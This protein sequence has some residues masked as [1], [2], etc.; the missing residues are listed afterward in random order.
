M[1]NRRIITCVASIV[2]ALAMLLACFPSDVKA[3][4]NATFHMAA[5]KK[6]LEL[7]E[8]RQAGLAYL[9]LATL[10]GR[11]SYGMAWDPT[12]GTDQLHPSV[13]VRRQKSVQDWI[14]MG[15][16][17]GDEPEGPMALR[18][19]YNPL[20]N[21]QPWLTDQQWI[22][23]QLQR[24]VS[25]TIR[26]PEISLVDWAADTQKGEIDEYFLPQKYSWPDAKANFRLALAS[27]DPDNDYYGAAWRAVGETMHLVA[28]LTLPPHVRND[29]H[30][31]FSR[32][33]GLIKVGDP[34]PLEPSTLAGPVDQYDFSAGGWTTAVDYE[35]DVIQM[36]RQLA[37]WTNANFLSKDTIPLPGWTTTANGGPIFPSPNPIG[38][39]PNA[40]G[41]IVYNVDGTEYRMVRQSAIY[42]SGVAPRDLYVIDGGVI[43]DQRKLLIPTAVRAAEAVIERFLPRFEVE[44]E[45]EEDSGTPGQYSVHGSLIH[46][47]GYEW[48]AERPG[49]GDERLI[50]RNGAYV[51]VNGAKSAVPLYNNDNL[52]EFTIAV[53]ASPG[54]KV[55]VLYDLGGY[56]IES[57]TFTIKASQQEYSCRVMLEDT[58][59]NT[60]YYCDIKFFRDGKQYGET[61]SV[62]NTSHLGM[63]GEMTF[64]RGHYTAE[65]DYAPVIGWKHTT[66]EFNIPDDL[67]SHDWLTLIVPK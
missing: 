22:V 19:F 45:I 39:T 43:L 38:L 28:D 30:A 57:E 29:G 60:A 58:E 31:G 2:F 23:N 52:N 3:W 49:V 6:A 26:N 44:I 64:E 65:V 55:K 9:Q 27:T 13:S 7:F 47:R 35:Q 59:G 67:D 40:Y 63:I 54:D 10:S 48:A 8:T 12:D 51:V 20:N 5:N 1:E 32:L 16:F 61:L 53:S 15:G 36:M 42:R 18:H 46:D 34:D 24:Y 37:S 33:W 41:Y 4:D 50:V 17:S 21:A 11:A 56:T 66:I 14:I 25:S 62:Q